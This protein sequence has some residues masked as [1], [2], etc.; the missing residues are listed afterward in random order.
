MAPKKSRKNAELEKE[1]GKENDTG[2]GKGKRPGQ[3]VNRLDNQSGKHFAVMVGSDQPLLTKDLL[4]RTDIEKIGGSQPGGS[5]EGSQ[6]V[7]PSRQAANPTTQKV[8]P[9]LTLQLTFGRITSLILEEFN[10][11]C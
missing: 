5:K 10:N 1:K 8:P 11:T 7:D 3:K 6:K 9:K 4:T 2:K